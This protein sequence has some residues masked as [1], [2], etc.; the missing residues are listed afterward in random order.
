MPATPDQMADLVCI[1]M[2][3]GYWLHTDKAG[4]A[5]LFNPKNELATIV[6]PVVFDLLVRRGLIQRRTTH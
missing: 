4:T 6:P 5:R 2:A 1:A 3:T